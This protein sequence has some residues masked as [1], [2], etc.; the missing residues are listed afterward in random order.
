MFQRTED[1]KKFNGNIKDTRNRIEQ[2]IGPYKYSPNIVFVGMI[3]AGKSSLSCSLLKKRLTVQ[4]SGKRRYLDGEGVGLGLDACTTIP[5]ISYDSQ[6]QMIITDLPG[7]E[8]NRSDELE[9]LNS[10]AID[11]LFGIFPNITKNYKIVLV[12]T[13]HD[14]QTNKCSKLIDSFLRIK[15]MFPKYQE[16]K[17][18]FGVIIT[19]GENEWKSN[20]YI[21]FFNEMYEHTSSLTSEMIEIH[22]FMNSYKDNIFTFPQPSPENVGKQYEFND[23]ERLMRFLKTKYCQN[24]EHQVAI[25]QTTESNLLLSYKANIKNVLNCVKEICQKIN[26]KYTYVTDSSNI[27]KWLDFIGEIIK[28]K[29]E[30]VKDFE[31]IIKRFIPNYSF[32]DLNLSKLSELS[33]FDEVILRVMPAHIDKSYLND[34]IQIWSHRTNEELTTKYKNAREKE[35]LKHQEEIRRKKEEEERR[36]QE[37]I[38]RKIEEQKR[39]NKEMQIEIEKREKLLEQDRKRLEAARK[40]YHGG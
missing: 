18:T 2:K 17:N 29:I 37:E 26:N 25:S 27:K 7:F 36:Q 4:V 31:D 11:D 6:N 23:S 15:K 19:K 8:D 3:G 14:F 32:Y 28:K 9:I 39:R 5:S 12:V 20:D 13:S 34:A 22:N 33:Q 35:H 10:I 40:S 38:A 30:N 16:I 1:I 21:D 24:P